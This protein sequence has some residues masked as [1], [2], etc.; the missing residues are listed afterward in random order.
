LVGKA[1]PVPPSN[2][3]RRNETQRPPRAC[4]ITGGA[5]RIGRAITLALAG[6]GYTVA[7]HAR[8]SQD[9]AKALARDLAAKGVRADVVTGDL[10][11][12]NDVAKLVPAAADAVGPLTLLVNCASEFEPDE[13]G[14]LDP[15]RYERHFA[16]NLRAPLFLA[17]AFAAQAPDNADASIVNILD[18]RVFRPTPQFFSYT[19]TKSALYT[20]TTTM[21]QQFAPRIRVNAVAPGPTLPSPRQDAAAFAR[22]QAALPLGRG[23]TPEDVASAVVFL[24]GAASVTGTT[25]PVDGGQRLSWR[26]EDASIE[27]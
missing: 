7:I 18:Q 16:I 11:D 25:V 1:A 9:A 22:Q 13:I 6:A 12:H 27:E 23:P 4:L 17:Q 24:A 8:R 5:Q 2:A 21:A 26:T 3:H 19:L 20:A 14:R 15:T 10:A